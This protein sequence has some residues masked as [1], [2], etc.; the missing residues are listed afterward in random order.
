MYFIAHRQSTCL[1]VLDSHVQ[2]H[3]NVHP[4]MSFASSIHVRCYVSFGSIEGYAVTAET[5]ARPAFIATSKPCYRSC[6]D[7][8]FS[9]GRTLTSALV[10]KCCMPRTSCKMRSDG[11][12]PQACALGPH[13]HAPC[14]AGGGKYLATPRPQAMAPVWG[15][16]RC[17][18]ACTTTFCNSAPF[19]G[20]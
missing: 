17:I 10:S 7:P 9:R 1:Q 19:T 11:C 14:S 13:P 18:Y 8:L 4:L 2:G 15:I 6:L 12:L 5:A 16:V 3:I 20:L